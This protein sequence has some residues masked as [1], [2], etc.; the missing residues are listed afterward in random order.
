MPPRRVLIALVALLV[1]ELPLLIPPPFGLTD[2]LVFWRAGQLVAGGGSPYDMAAWAETQRRYASGHLLPFVAQDHPVWVY[3]A[4]TA[5][6]FVPFGL[7][8]YP[9]GPWLLHLAYLATSLGAAFLFARSL[10]QR[11]QRTA[12]I[13]AVVAAVFQP[14]V[15]AARYGQF[16]G[17]LL[18]GL[19]LVVRGLRDRRPLPLAAGALILATKPQL[20]LLLAPAVAGH[21][22]WTHR[23]RTVLALTALLAAVAALTTWRYP[24]S[25]AL[26]ARGAGDRTSA[27]TTYSSTW[28]FAHAVAGEAWWLAGGALVG[29]GLLASVATYR[30]LPADLRPAGLVALAAALSLVITPVDLHYDQVPLAAAL[31]LAV[32]LGRR[33]WQLALT[34][35][36]GI[37]APWL[38]FF[39]A[40]ATGGPDSQAVSGI[41]PLLAIGALLVAT[42]PPLAISSSS[43][44]IAS[45]PAKLK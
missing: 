8:P 33:P 18:L 4:W 30:R 36:L 25:L 32:A 11:F 5:L 31:I 22:L 40:L 10:P 34:L 39:T 21:L 41:V 38:L 9:L 37:A 44:A 45:T 16:G 19:V 12:A 6:L 43:A 29:L 26:V 2:H 17:F 7:L 28:A 27:F 24:E 1:A 20:F 35:V 15:I 13:G 23:A 14:L 42:L 3:P